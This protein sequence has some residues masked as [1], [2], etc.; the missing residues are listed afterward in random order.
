[1]TETKSNPRT[2]QGAR[3]KVNGQ[4][5]RGQFTPRPWSAAYPTLTEGTVRERVTD[6]DIGTLA[7]ALDRGAFRGDHGSSGFTCPHCERWAAE[8]TSPSLWYCSACEYAGTRYGLVQLVL[9]D[10]YAAVALA[11]GGTA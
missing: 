6:A 8:V 11:T 2:G 5:D 3:A 10:A 1:M 9:A 7:R 4:A